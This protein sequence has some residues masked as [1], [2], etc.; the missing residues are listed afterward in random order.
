MELNQLKAQKLSTMKENETVAM[1]VK[2]VNSSDPT[3]ENY[4]LELREI[5]TPP[6]NATN[7]SNA[8]GILNLGD[9]RFNR[10]GARAD[11]PLVKLNQL[12]SMC[13]KLRKEDVEALSIG[14]ELFIGLS[15]PHLKHNGKDTYFKLCVTETFEGTDYQMQAPKERCK[16][17]G[18][19]PDGDVVYGWDKD[20]NKK[21]KIFSINSTRTAE[22]EVVDG[23]IVAF[24]NYDKDHSWIET[25]RENTVSTSENYT[26]GELVNTTTGEVFSDQNL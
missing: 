11:Y 16:R 14:E 26:K 21:R 19:Y 12:L 20:A 23:E 7:N 18:K 6:T 2:R 25:H 9:P 13:P 1:S 15:N 22:A 10:R 5:I 4:K 24:T 8:L 17:T 3:I